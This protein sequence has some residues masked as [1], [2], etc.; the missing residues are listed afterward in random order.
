MDH[1]AVACVAQGAG[2]GGLGRP[3]SRYDGH[4]WFP[5]I[6]VQKKI[7]VVDEW[8]IRVVRLF[9]KCFALSGLGT[10]R[11]EAK[12]CLGKSRRNFTRIISHVIEP[13][14]QRTCAIRSANRQHSV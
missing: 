2:L 1:L 12:V 4:L 8:D 6:S 5:K 13:P 14:S 10:E 7:I 11:D 3:T 9:A